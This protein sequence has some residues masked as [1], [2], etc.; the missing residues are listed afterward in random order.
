MSAPVAIGKKKDF[1][2]NQTRSVEV[3]G[4][5]VCVGRVGDNFYAVDDRCTHAESTLSGGDIEDDCEISCPLHGARFSLR[6][7][8]ALTLPAVKPV[9]VHK[10]IV[11]GDDVGIEL[12]D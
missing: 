11:S 10:V 4:R 7:G 6:T 2:D 12:C 8:E 5:L 3:N 9:K 1:P